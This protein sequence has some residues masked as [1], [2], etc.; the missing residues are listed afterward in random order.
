MLPAAGVNS[1]GQPIILNRGWQVVQTMNLCS[2]FVWA[3]STLHTWCH[4]CFGVSLRARSETT[5]VILTCLCAAV[6]V[7][8]MEGNWELTGG[9]TVEPYLIR[10]FHFH[11]GADSCTGSEHTVDSRR[12]PLEVG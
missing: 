1:V 8:I 4:N 7:N 3:D 12:Y 6:Q 5:V 11:W 10:Q 2:W 9:S